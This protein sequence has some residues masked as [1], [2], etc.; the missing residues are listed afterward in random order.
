M[1]PEADDPKPLYDEGIL[2]VQQ[3]VGALFWVG[4]A[5]N[6]KLLVVLSAI[7]SHQALA[8]KEMNKAI[9]QLLDYCATYP[10]Y[11]ILYWSSDMI[12]SGHLD[13]GFNK[14]TKARRSMWYPQQ[15]RL[16]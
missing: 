12:L 13:A 2:R 14:E 10:D 4:R 5:V 16:R 11:G 8:T 15:Q 9:N 7:V 6:I 1:A 3:F